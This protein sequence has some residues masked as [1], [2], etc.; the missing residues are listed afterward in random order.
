MAEAQSQDGFLV[1]ELLPSSRFEKIEG[2]RFHLTKTAAEH[3]AK[4][5]AVTTI[6]VVI[7]PATRVSQGSR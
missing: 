5:R 7:I 4:S 3:D 6:P 2:L 1:G